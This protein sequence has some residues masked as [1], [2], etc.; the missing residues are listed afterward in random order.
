MFFLI[1]GV[2]LSVLRTKDV[3]IGGTRLTNVKYTCSS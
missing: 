3:N 1:K 2:R